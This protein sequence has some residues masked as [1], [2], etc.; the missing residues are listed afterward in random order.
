MAEKTPLAVR[1]TNSVLR[2]LDP[3]EM[4]NA[5]QREMDGFWRARLRL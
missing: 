5:L 3:F 1:Q 2:R 4:L